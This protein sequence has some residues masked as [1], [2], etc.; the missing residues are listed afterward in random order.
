MLDNDIFF[1]II[2]GLICFSTKLQQQ[3]QT[4]RQGT[5]A[6]TKSDLPAMQGKQKSMCY[7]RK[8]HAFLC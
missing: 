6:G 7:F 2:E 8:T 3:Q 1:M 5:P 4:M